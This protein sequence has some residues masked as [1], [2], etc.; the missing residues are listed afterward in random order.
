[1]SNIGFSYLSLIIYSAYQR[2]TETFKNHSERMEPT[3]L[4]WCRP[5]NHSA[6]S[7]MHLPA[8]KEKLYVKAE[9]CRVSL[10][11]DECEDRPRLGFKSRPEHCVNMCEKPVS[12]GME[13]GFF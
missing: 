10:S 6:L 2:E 11:Q 3:T 13:K 5:V 12:L 4:R 9:R 1:M 7:S 8:L